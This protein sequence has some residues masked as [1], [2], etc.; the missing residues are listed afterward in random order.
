MSRLAV[1]IFGPESAGNHLLVECMV[2]AGCQGDSA[3]P[4]YWDKQSPGANRVVEG[5]SIPFADTWPDI[6]AI[7]ERWQSRG[8]AVRIVV[9][10]RN[11][12]VLMRSQ[13]SHRHVRDATESRQSLQRAY[14]YIF[15]A[16]DRHRVEY[17]ICHYDRLV[18]EP[19]AELGGL[20]DWLGLPRID[21]RF[22]YDGN[23]HYAEDPA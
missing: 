13:V 1:V 15:A 2:R 17:A 21:T 5:K 4:Y 10:T 9:I 11:W 3:N 7:I 20:L 18:A 22:I 8:Y 12:P 6:T 19:D 14:C 16:I 23:R